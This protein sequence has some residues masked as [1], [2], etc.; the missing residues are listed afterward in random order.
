VKRIAVLLLALTAALG[1][2]PERLPPPGAPAPSLTDPADAIPGDLDLAVRIDLAKM[3][4][5][6][7][8]ELFES[9]RSRA[10][11]SASGADPGSDRLL[12]DALVAADTV[13]IALRPGLPPDLT[14][15]VMILRGDFSRIDP[16]SYGS[17]PG[18][19]TPTDLGGGW[20][21]WERDKPKARALAARLYL[22][23][24]SLLV[25]VSTAEIDSV[26]RS[27]EQRMDDPRVAPPAKGVISLEA[28]APALADQI[29]ERSPA[30][31]RLLERGRKL[32]VH[33]DLGAT[34]LAAELELEL[35]SPEGASRTAE[36]AALFAKALGDEGGAAEALVR[37]LRI[38][39]VGDSVV[40]RLKLSHR[41]LAVIVPEMTR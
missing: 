40:A 12:A 31:A 10:A 35:D 8:P 37:G 6:L 17:D 23:D 25:L 11:L 26:E 24:K 34:G 3:R 38:E 29:L 18:W 27:L 1:C 41:E 33:A 2:G 32:R 22:R 21:L 9:L 16:Q 28:R 39:A 7:G 13:W 14:D 4:S 20:M 36:A 5:A 30:A 15:N 19:G